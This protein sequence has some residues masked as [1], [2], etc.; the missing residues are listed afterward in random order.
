M[1]SE[2]LLVLLSDADDTMIAEA[3][4]DHKRKKP[5]LRWGALAACLC[6]ITVG[7]IRLRGDHVPEATIQPWSSTMD[8]ED[9]FRNSRGDE[10]GQES[11]SPN[12]IMPPYALAVSLDT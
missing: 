2:E 7:V 12:L 6:L 4:E 8:A 1:K 11:H 3:K 5:W 10:A 9:Y